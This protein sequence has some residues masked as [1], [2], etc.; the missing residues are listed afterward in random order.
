MLCSNV[1]DDCEVGAFAIKIH[2]F[3]RFEKDLKDTFKTES[4]GKF[5][6]DL[7]S[8]LSFSLEKDLKSVIS[9]CF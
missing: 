2:L 1:G 8:D 6:I 5:E 3:D 9:F 7:K 4:K